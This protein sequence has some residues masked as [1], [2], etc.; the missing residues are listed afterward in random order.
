MEQAMSTVPTIDGASRKAVEQ[1][2]LA[3]KRIYQ[4]G[5][6]RIIDA[7]GSCDTPEYMMAGD[8][9]ATELRALLDAPVVER[10]SVAWRGCNSDGEVVTEWIDGVPPARM[11]DLSG[12]SASFDRIETAYAAPPE[13]AELQ[14]TIDQLK[15]ENEALAEKYE[16]ARDRKNS[17]TAL[18]VEN[19]V[20]RMR[21]KELDLLFGRYLLGMKAAV[22][23]EE[24]NGQGMRWIYNA[25]AGS[26]ELPPEGEENAQAYFDREI[27]A[28]DN[29]MQEVMAFHEARCIGIS[30]QPPRK[31]NG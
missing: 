12:N 28:V 23:D 2:L 16:A 8:P 25:L 29:G 9:T 26:G 1:A 3:M 17:I 14:A 6:D 4:A 15:A 31:K 10:Q 13:V 18:Q 11:V 27:V 24:V 7:G 22:I 5:Y 30:G 21:I 20:A 19:E